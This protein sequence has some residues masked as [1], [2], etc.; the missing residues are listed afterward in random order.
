[1]FFACKLLEAF[2]V[3]NFEANL[4]LSSY[5]EVI[6]YQVSSLYIYVYIYVSMLNILHC[7]IKKSSFCNIFY[8]TLKDCTAYKI[9]Q[10]KNNFIRGK[11]N[12]TII[13]KLT[14]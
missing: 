3:H 7:K 1:M 6:I 2:P 4:R 11:R 10:N 8:Q 5:D 12:F 9:F 13:F 14:R